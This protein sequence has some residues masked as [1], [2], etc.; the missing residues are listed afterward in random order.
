MSFS[1]ASSAVIEAASPDATAVDAETD[2]IIAIDKKL[3][4][5]MLNSSGQA[6]EINK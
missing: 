6:R 4:I 2:S 5:F 3:E 1:R